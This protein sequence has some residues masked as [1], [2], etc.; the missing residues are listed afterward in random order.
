MNYDKQIS[1]LTKNPKLIKAHF[2]QAIGLFKWIGMGG[3]LV[4][5]RDPFYYGHTAIINKITDVKLTEGIKKDKHLPSNLSEITVDK[6]QHL[7]KWRLR[8]D[9]IEN[10]FK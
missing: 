6:L 1:I 8:I 3:C 7:K 4:T 9:K 10:K 2:N 5:I